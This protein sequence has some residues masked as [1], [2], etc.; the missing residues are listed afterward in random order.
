M[1]Y[2]QCVLGSCYVV[3]IIITIILLQKLLAGIERQDRG[4]E[5]TPPR[6]HGKRPPCPSIS[7]P[8]IH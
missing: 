4:N 2:A 8:T 3:L 1:K 7:T 6:Q 5:E